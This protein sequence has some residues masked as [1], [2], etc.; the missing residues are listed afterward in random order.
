[1]SH[2]QNI[3]I[4]DGLKFKTLIITTIMNAV[5]YNCKTVA[6]KLVDYKE[7]YIYLTGIIKASADDEDLGRNDFISFKNGS[8]SIIDCNSETK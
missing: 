6:D 8:N 5:K 4:R 7:G 1:M 3:N 2:H